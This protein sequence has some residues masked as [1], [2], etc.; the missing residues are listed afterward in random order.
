MALTEVP[1]EVFAPVNLQK[2]AEITMKCINY[3]KIDHKVF[4]E[5]FLDWNKTAYHWDGQLHHC[6]SL[7]RNF[8]LDLRKSNPVGV[9]KKWRLAVCKQLRGAERSCCRIVC[10]GLNSVFLFVLMVL[11][12]PFFE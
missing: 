10:D 3:H 8:R 12:C 5:S 6:S 7:T 2:F 11:T 1:Q 9:L 4:V